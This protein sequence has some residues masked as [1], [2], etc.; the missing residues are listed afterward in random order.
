[1]EK[2][3]RA[4]GDYLRGDSGPPPP[5]KE[6]DSSVDARV[7]AAA[8][9]YLQQWKNLNLD[10]ELMLLPQQVRENMQIS[11]DRIFN[12]GIH[13]I[14]N[15]EREYDVYLK[16]L[17][18][19]TVRIASVVENARGSQITFKEDHESLIAGEKVALQKSTA[20]SAAPP[21]DWSDSD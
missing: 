11:F 13:A 8:S 6:M 21:C 7:Q 10:L 4:I 2:V 18:A 16:E 19:V 12:K 14:N 20:R 15:T 9:Q 1:M 5:V 17:S 3:T